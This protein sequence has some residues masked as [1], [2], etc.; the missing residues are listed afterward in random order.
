ME[1][2]MKILITIMFLIWHIGA[3]GFFGWNVMPESADEFI[4]DGILLVGMAILWGK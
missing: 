1:K 3:S 2:S 4:I